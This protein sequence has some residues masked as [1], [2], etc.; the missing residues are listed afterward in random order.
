MEKEEKQVITEQIEEKVEEQTGEAVKEEAA[1][2]AAPTD[3]KA[4]IDQLPSELVA[5]VK[6]K[7]L[8]D[9]ENEVSVEASGEASEEDKAEAEDMAKQEAGKKRAFPKRSKKTTALMIV[10]E[11]ILFAGLFYLL[12]LNIS[13]TPEEVVKDNGTGIVDDISCT[14]GNLIVNGVNVEVPTDKNVAYNVAY[15]WGE[16]DTDYPT[17]PHSITATYHGEEDAQLYDIS[18]YR[19]SFT[20]TAE[21]PEGKNAENWFS[22]W[23]VVEEGDV[24]QSTRDTSEVHGFL[25]TANQDHNKNEE[26]QE[27]PS[28]PTS[29]YYFT[30][31]T[32][33]G[34]S[35]YIL[36]GILYDPASDEDF[37]AVFSKSLES[38]SVP[39]DVALAAY[40]GGRC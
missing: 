37:R 10:L 8:E 3:M 26:D 40:P 20:P 2:A 38:I 25:I 14:D 13:V 36:E 24:I 27:S 31:Q 18:L 33:D 1:E 16:A 21:I 30:V 11:C 29:T 22:D 32:A 6:A 35:V 39:H 28:Y 17:V 23:K 9:A 12:T 19:D 5:A 15:S 7:A 34:I 4:L